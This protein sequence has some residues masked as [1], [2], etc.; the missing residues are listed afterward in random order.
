MI[1]E[2]LI[3]YIANRLKV[4]KKL[5]EVVEAEFWRSL[6]YYI[7]HPLEAKQGILINNLMTFHIPAINIVHF[8]KHTS[9]KLTKEEVLFHLQL[10]KNLT[11]NEKGKQDDYE[12][13][14]RKK[15]PEAFEPDGGN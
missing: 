13:L 12:G 10:Y 15:Y 1:D 8:T 2:D 4:D 3:K 14:L 9:K 11:Y 5:V 6:R 7:S